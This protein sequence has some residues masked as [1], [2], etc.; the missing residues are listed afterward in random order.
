[1]LQKPGDGVQSSKRL[2]AVSSESSFGKSRA[3]LLKGV[4]KVHDR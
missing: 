1:M 3:K 4:A 2:A